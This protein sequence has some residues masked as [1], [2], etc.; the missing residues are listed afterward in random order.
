M[1]TVAAESR[2]LVQSPTAAI[3]ARRRFNIC[4]AIHGFALGGMEEHAVD[5]A[6]GL[7]ARGHEV[8]MLLPF[9]GG[10]PLAPLAPRLIAA[11]V[12]VEARNVIELKGARERA[13]AKWQLARWLNREKFDIFHLQRF[14]PYHSNALPLVAALAGIR[15][16]FVSEQDPGLEAVPLSR[17][18]MV[19]GDAWVTKW[20]VAA[21]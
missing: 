6:S 19:L 17:F 14:N 10:G 18:A 16:R 13:S 8:T 21:T 11:G 1:K 5:L 12:G 20:I 9:A 7:V 3:N 2:E 4:M 15:R